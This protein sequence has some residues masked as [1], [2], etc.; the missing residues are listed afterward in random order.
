MRERGKVLIIEDDPNW[1]YDLKKDL[2]AEGFFAEITDN[3]PSA[4]EKVKTELFHF[5]TLDMNLHDNKKDIDPDVFEGWSILDI[6]E[7]LRV[8]EKTP[9]MV[10]TGHGFEYNT[11]KKDKNLSALYFMEKG[12]YEPKKFIDIV[13]RETNRHDLKFYKDHR[14]NT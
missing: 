13:V 12:E 14:T 10:I 6:V 1:Q 4:I 5:I 7:K 9:I 11:L 2:Q 3:L 8:Q